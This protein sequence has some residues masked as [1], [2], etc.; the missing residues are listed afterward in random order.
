MKHYAYVPAI[1]LCVAFLALS[2]WIASAQSI[3]PFRPVQGGTGTSSIP[4]YGQVLVGNSS[5]TYSLVSTSSLGIVGAADGAFSTTSADYWKSVRN[6]FSTTSVDYWETTQAPRGGSGTVGTSTIPTGGHLAFWSS[7]GYPSL[8]GSVAT[9]TLS[10]SG[11]VSVSANRYVIGGAATVLCATASGSTQGCLSASDWTTF[12]AKE[13]ALTFSYPLS[14]SANAI[15]FVGLG[16]TTTWTT[17]NLA[18]VTNGNTLESIATSSLNIAISDTTGTLAVARG[19]TGATTLNNLIT[20]A[21][22]TT[23]NYLATL[24]SSGS[25]TVGNSGSENAAATVNL[26]LGNANTWTALQTFGNSST[27]LGSFSYASSTNYYGAGLSSCTGAANK[28]TWSSGRFSCETDQTGG[29]SGTPDSKWATSTIVSSSIHTAGASKVGIGTTSPWGMLSLQTAAN[30][31]EPAFFIASSSGTPF[32]AVG[33]SDKFT[34]GGAGKNIFV[35]AINDATPAVSDTAKPGQVNINGGNMTVSA[36]GDVLYGATLHVGSPEMSGS[37]FYGAEAEFFA[38]GASVAATTSWNVLEASDVEIKGGTIN[39]ASPFRS[40]TGARVLTYGGSWSTWTGAMKGGDA[41][42]RAG[43]STNEGS[44]GDVNISAGAGLSTGGSIFLNAGYAAS[45]HGNVIIGNQYPG[46]RLG[47]GTTSPYAKLSVVGDVV[48][49][50]F[51]ATSSLSVGSSTPMT[52]SIF[53]VGTS[54]WT[55]IHVNS[56]NGNIGI[57]CV[58]SSASRWAFGCGSNTNVNP[59]INLLVQDASDS[60]FGAAVADRFVGMKV[61]SASTPGIFGFNYLA[62]VPLDINFQEFGANVGIGTSTPWAKLSVAS[63]T[64]DY[65][66]PVFAISTSTGRYGQLFTVSGTTS[67]FRKNDPARFD[68]GVRVSVGTSPFPNSPALDQLEVEG[69]INQ[70]AM[71]IFCDAFNGNVT[72]LTADTNYVCGNFFFNEDNAAVSDTAMTDASAT[73]A[74]VR[75]GTAGTIAANGD[76]GSISLQKAGSVYLDLASSTPVAEVIMRIGLPQNATSSLYLVGFS[77][78]AGNSGSLEGTPSDACAFT[79][80]STATTGNWWLLSRASGTATYVDTGVASSTRVSGNGDFYKFRI[81]ASPNLCV[82][83]ITNLRTGVTTK[84]S[85]TASMGFWPNNASLV[86]SVGQFAAGLT[87]ELH[88]RTMRLWLSGYNEPQ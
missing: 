33:S 18:R 86:A 14:R 59:N 1:A 11:G 54:T 46:T 66:A 4:T 78:N 64:Y 36:T 83:Y 23:G 75:T 39:I 37:E 88:V 19:G 80:S 82:G 16:T 17:G 27:T 9:G 41:D 74:R 79:A 20:L 31:S 68:D 35:S 8:L 49:T 53:T 67:T 58:N 12:N 5:G 25:I 43:E 32:L 45:N 7:N 61:G 15:S 69:R 70:K 26:N 72:Q 76:G 85:I 57:G 3:N 65:S 55:G 73:Y 81:E 51:M 30:P 47:I 50:R 21:T 56:T 38:G 34:G 52:N 62:G 87:K 84:A 42:I 28:L 77:S 2:T 6:F 44:G 63:A 10:G 24:T 60:R 71:Y 13:S 40:V 22:H 29:G 48:A